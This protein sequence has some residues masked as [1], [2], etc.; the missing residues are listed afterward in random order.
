MKFKYKIQP[1]QTEAVEAVVRVFEGQPNIG[2]ALYQ[3]DLGEEIPKPLNLQKNL[4][5]SEEDDA[6]ARGFRNADFIHALDDNAL[7]EN[8]RKIQAEYNIPLTTSLSKLHD[9]CAL[10]IE[11]ETGT[12]KT[13]V[14]IKTMFELNKRYGWTKFIVIV[15]SIAIREGVSKSFE[16]MTDHFMEHYGKKARYFIY[17]S[18]NL[19]QIDSFSSSADINVMII[20]TQAFASSLDEKS[21]KKALENQQKGKNDKNLRIYTKRDEFGSR[22]PIDVIAANHP[23]I[24]MDEPQKMG[25]D[26]TLKSLKRF[27][28][29]F[30]INYSATHRVQHNLVYALDAVDAYQYRLVKKITVKGFQLHG[31][32][33]TEGYIYAEKIILSPKEPPSVRAEYEVKHHAGIK[34]ESHIL[35]VGDDLFEKS[36]HL[37]QYKNC[38]ILEI[39]PFANRIALSNHKN[40]RMELSIGEATQDL[41]EDDQRRIQIRETLISHFEKEAKL[42]ERGIKTLSLFFIDKVANYREYDEDGNPKLGKYGV[43]FE[44]EYKA[45]IDEYRTLF[46]PEYNKYL[47]QID[48]HETHNGY[49]SIDKKTGR[50]IDSDISNR[51]A[52]KGLSKD[53]SAYD[54]ILKNKERLLSFEEPTRFIFSH[55]A[56]REGWDNPNVFQICTLKNSDSDINRRQEVGRGMRL[57]VNQDG[58][59]MD[60]EACGEAVHELNRLTVIASESY[61]DFVSNLQK[62]MSEVLKQRAVVVDDKLFAG[63]I[64]RAN[65][66]NAV[67][68]DEKQARKIYQYLLKNDYIDADTGLISQA[69]RDDRANGTLKP[70]S[71]EALKC[72]E[73]GIHTLIQSLYETPSEEEM[74]EDDSRPSVHLNKPN[75]RFYK[76]EF[77]NL[78]KT[79]NHKYA[80]TIKFDSKELIEHAVNAI[81]AELNIT[82]LKYTLMEGSQNENISADQIQGKSSFD[83]SKSTTRKLQYADVT[84]VRYDLIGKIAEGT[85]LTRKTVTAIL[86]QI[87]DAKFAMF[88]MNPESFIDKTT[89]IINEKKAS[90]FVEHLSNHKPGVELSYHAVE[91]NMS[92]QDDPYRADIFTM[93]HQHLPI[94]KAYKAQKAIQDY[95]YTDGT[96]EN[97]IER[98]FAKDLDAAEEVNIY[99]KLPKGFYI[100][101][102]VGH[103]S[104]DWAVVFYEGKV[105]HIYFIAETK[106]SMSSM[107]LRP[108]EQAK[109]DSA[110]LLFEKLSNGM[111]KYDHVTNYQELLNLV[112]N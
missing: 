89:T 91:V 23:I 111:V 2:A 22:R 67:K 70:M 96:S 77:Q 105:K 45:L 55:S 36:N 95:I 74:Y 109:I 44:E 101:T 8:I 54:L 35:R 81:N 33:G 88:A 72:V 68:L 63:K 82:P 42:F 80:Y 75:E 49:F 59:R 37:E 39:D 84:H 46:T 7:L 30:F 92:D 52:E 3:R 40:L 61:Q 48:V 87:S 38:K 13:Y 14:Y 50:M 16:N 25:G 4:F 11:M 47:S 57:C 93:E 28:P 66:D 86:K 58:D 41:L 5:A 85:K 99:A 9:C 1:Y 98:T 108:I 64:V 20:N 62:E 10:D 103:Y 97:S 34:R 18:D 27:N 29:L 17:N 43:I 83:Q 76:K 56:L 107:E 106:G 90:M 79:I 94:T 100:P 71:D 19:S 65:N 112:Q 110:K 32:H 104:P 12:G 51:G 69:Y 73:A 6:D 31:L 53:I 26:A 24:V 78:W 60:A 102:P 15:P 21:E